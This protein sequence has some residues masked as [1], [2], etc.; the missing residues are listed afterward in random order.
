MKQ[1]R[2]LLPI[3]TAILIT[4][5]ALFTVVQQA[6]AACDG[7]IFVNQASPAGTPDGCSWATAYPTLQDA[8]AVAASGDELWVA[9]G[10]YYP[11]QGAGQAPGNRA[12]TFSLA[13]GVA[14]YG[15][16]TGTELT[17]TER[18][19]NPATNG[20]VLS[21]DI[22]TLGASADNTYHVLTAYSVSPT[23]RLDGFTI[24]AGNTNGSPGGFGGGMYLQDSSPSLANLLFT[25]NLA[26][27]GAGLF[28][29]SITPL[30]SQPTLVDVTF[31]YNTAANGGGA[32]SQNSQP[33]FERVLFLDNLATS[34]AG[35]GLNVQTISD[36][37]PA[38]TVTLTDVTFRANTANGGGGLFL[39]NNSALTKL[40]NVTFD[41]NTAQR[42]G[43]GL[44][45]EY[46]N[47][48][49][50]N[51]TFA[52]NI[53]ND[54]LADPKGGGALMNVD[55]SPL[56]INVTFSGNASLFVGGD[57]I[58]NA[59]GL[60]GAGSFP[61]IK[62]SILWD[63]NDEISTA[64]GGATITD[65]L[66]KG[67]CPAG[68][69]CTNVIAADP[70]LGPLANHGGFADTM[71]INATSPA[72]NTGSNADCP[73]DDQRGVLRPQ[74]GVCEMGA[75]EV[76]G[77]L[78]PTA[79]PTVTPTPTIT[80][81]PPTPTNTPIPP[82]P[83]NTPVP[84]TATPTATNTPIPPT[85]TNTPIPP[86]ATNT[87]IPPTPT[88]TPIPPTATP[89][90][91]PTATPTPSP[92]VPVCSEFMHVDAAS[93]AN[94]PDGCGWA[95]AYTTLQD[96]LAMAANGDELWVAAGTYYPD[97]GAGQA[98]GN[99]AST[100]S[101]VNGVAIYG[102][103]SGN[104][105]TRSQRN[106]NPATNGT[107]LSG[108]INEIGNSADNA[109]RVVTAYAVGPTALLDGFTIADG[110]AISA[111]GQFGGGMYIEDGS[112]TLSNLLFANNQAYRGGGLF[113]TSIT[114]LTS[115]PTLVDVTFTA[116]SAAMGGGVF[117][118][119]SEPVFERAL[120][121]GNLATGGAGG[122]LNVQ[123]IA[124]DDP[125][126][127]V[128]LTN[129]T[130]RDNIATGGGGLFLGNSSSLT[131]LANVTFDGNF[132]R[133]RGGA[134][135]N[136]YSNPTLIN[137]TF[138]NNISDDNQADPRG[139]GAL[140][141]IDS[142]PIL[143]NATFSGNASVIAGGDAIRNA[144]GLT[145]AG[146][147]PVIKNSILWDTNDEISTADVGGA[148]ITDSLLKGGCPAGATC[149][150]VFAADP[151]L[152][153]LANHGG[154]ADTMAISATSPAWNTGSNAD[155]PFEDQRNVLRPQDGVCEMGA[156]EVVGGLLP[157]A[158][159]T[160]TPTPIP[161][162]ATNTPA[163]PTA[164]STPTNTPLPPTATNTPVP[165]TATNTPTNT[166]LPP[167]ATNTPVPPTATN[168]PTNTPLPPTATNTPVPPTA[169]NTPTNTPLPPTATNTP[170]PPT[171]TNTPTNT[172]LPPT[173]TNTP[174]P[175]TATNTPTNTPLPPTATNTPVPPTPTPATP[176]ILYLSSTTNGNSGGVAFA[177]EDIVTLNMTTNAW[178]M[179]FDGSD[180]G[181]AGDVNAFKLMPDGTILLSLTAPATIN[182]LGSVDDS[183]II[184]FTPVSLGSN[185][186]GSFTLY[187][188]G[189]DVGLSTNGEDIDSVGILPD[190]RLLIS[191][192]G[193]FS[194]PG[195]SGRDEDLI[196][197]TPTSLGNTTSGTWSLYFDGSDVNL[198][199]SSGEDVSGIWVDPA[200]N[201]IYLTTLGL[202]SVPGL[203]GGAAD[204]F[205]CTPGS[206]GANTTCSFSAFW[207]GAQNGFAGEVID[208]FGIVK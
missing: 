81:I 4:I 154:F 197:F 121:L 192:V 183:D 187:F 198:N 77:G 70:Q 14:I 148:T 199:D 110:N 23:A 146:S 61:V 91:P 177:D 5:V 98:S 18:N 194:V 92:T 30:T 103:F 109:H 133:R 126:V 172:P 102:G 45:N 72:W 158:T 178:A 88:N 196:A 155:C 179:Y 171:A 17:R 120:F 35:G 166:P 28:V 26:F 1:N 43:G 63:T 136:E 157:T 38:V 119:N 8:L 51:V 195:A 53:S 180:V 160:V 32:F 75:Y 54:N 10:T 135:L 6:R 116:N 37:D 204:I 207:I 95:T 142:S 27:R 31:A 40:A 60:T 85:P 185:T 205:I 19:P 181:I 159:P 165:P 94:N 2:Y 87:P 124:D 67:G 50:I 36:N 79:T 21:G 99:Q 123:T 139:G 128:I 118:Q 9:A 164:T 191:T 201:D 66:L 62:N 68:A 57:A 206:L 58:R 71:A 169:T 86:T 65:S 188:D 202:F 89:T 190:G 112:P 144:A 156:Y 34:G 111:Q 44:L 127:T 186:A 203:S 163:P 152:G 151:Q 11:D 42:R 100:F 129:V 76:V 69:T 170:V 208:G 41:G 114:P 115:Q 150:N 105:L 22:N 47:P 3:I 130:F 125:A 106:P 122:G 13:D 48:T 90:V 78:L 83:T 174:V 15:G 101:L 161:P 149:T 138:A 16:F 64:V 147:F 193:S 143:I 189:S 55:S 137:V 52:N 84:P 29:T 167:T 108:D 134:M 49:L 153:P 173:A 12:S 117:T 176:L 141:N 82:T 140:M 56:L 107:V 93:T 24:T 104:E 46:S 182:G 175:P 97:Q 200:N 80:P 74:D 132:A 113:V 25:G 20:T 184:R 131:T 168:T 145:G 33:V 73:V 162:T 59:A 7:T 39:G 96:A